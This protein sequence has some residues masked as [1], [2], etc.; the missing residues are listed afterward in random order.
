LRGR[1]LS[2]IIP[3]RRKAGGAKPEGTVMSLGITEIL[4]ILLIVGVIFGAG[5]L[6]KVMGDFGKGIRNFKDGLK[7]SEGEGDAPAPA[8]ATMTQAP[9]IDNK[10][11]PSPVVPLT[12]DE[13]AP[14]P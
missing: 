4:V 5:K 6:P 12:K 2:A 9:V 8:D 14:K 7:G 3:R 13:S 1:G 10:V 11:A